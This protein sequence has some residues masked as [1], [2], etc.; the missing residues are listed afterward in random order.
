MS[1]SFSSPG[2]RFVAVPV[3]FKPG[4]IWRLSRSFSSMGA[5]GG[6][7]GSRPRSPEEGRG[8]VTVPFQPREDLGAVPVPFQPRSPFPTLPCQPGAPQHP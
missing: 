1:R 3:P 4:M 7:C 2:E 5:V 8:A 6:C